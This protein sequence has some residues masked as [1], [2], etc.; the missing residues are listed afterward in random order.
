MRIVA[1]QLT[2]PSCC[3]EPWNRDAH[4]HGAFASADLRPD[5]A[6]RAQALLSRRGCADG[7]AVDTR[8]LLTHMNYPEIPVADDPSFLVRR[9]VTVILA[10]GRGARL[11]QL[12][13]RQTKPGVHFGGKFRIIDF[14][15]SNCLNS[16]LRRIAVVTQ[17]ESHAL[18]RHLQQGWS[19]LHGEL[20][21]MVD[22]L[23][24]HD[25]GADG[26]WYRGT[27][28]AVY[29]NWDIL[30]TTPHE[31]VVVLAG[32]HIYKMDYSV[33]LRD[34]VAHGHGCTIACTEM[35]RM[36]A[37]SFGVM[38]VDMNHH[39]T[40]FIEDPVDPPSMPDRPDRALVSMGIYIFD[41]AYLKRLLDNDALNE[42]SSH[43]FGRDIV[44]RAVADAR[45]IAHPFSRSVVSRVHTDA[46]P[47]YWRHVDT[48][49]SYW[50]ANLDLAAVIPKLDIYDPDW[51]IW[52]DQQQLPPAK[53]V[54]DAQGSRGTV[55]NTT[56]SGGC[57]VNGSWVKD[58]VLF[59][60]VRVESFCTILECV[61]MPDVNVGE[62][63]RLTRAIVD[64]GCRLPDG[65]VVG[66]DALADAARFERTD[67]GT[68]LVTQAMVRR[69]AAP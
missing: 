58:S 20:N 37:T 19:F 24:A 66:E 23:P 22:V 35:P 21:E 7:R 38:T 46:D 40:A 26:R 45:A 3:C 51:P 14:A 9:A 36:E 56:V 13:Q 59:S 50:A 16:G 41:A 17:Y 4:G 60:G 34:H 47:P 2:V 69:L 25:Q 63:C 42:D 55:I 11:R 10:G 64:A 18:M 31:Y 28:D 12:T 62:R 29:Q 6:V 48:L 5:G 39:I 8:Y 61:L 54:P 57:I 68:V 53:F 49:D 67:A 65:L 30:Q 27:S 52:T 15:L 32:D 33:M 1:R 43:D 44:P